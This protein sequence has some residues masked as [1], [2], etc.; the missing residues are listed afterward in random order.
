MHAHLEFGGDCVN[1]REFKFAL[2][3]LNKLFL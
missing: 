2:N 1:M 3:Y